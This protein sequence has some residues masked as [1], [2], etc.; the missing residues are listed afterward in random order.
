[1]RSHSNPANPD[2]NKFLKI[3]LPAHEIWVVIA[4]LAVAR[5]IGDWAAIAPPFSWLLSSIFHLGA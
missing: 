2:T 1:M 3:N 5:K 4:D